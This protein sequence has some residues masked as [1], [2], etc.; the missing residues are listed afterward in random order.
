MFRRAVAVGRYQAAP[1]RTQARY[2]EGV[3]P[4]AAENARPNRA[5]EGNPMSAA[6]HSIR[7][8]VVRSKLATCWRRHSIR[9]RRGVRPC[10]ARKRR[11]TWASLAPN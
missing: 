1:S 9:Y 4:N 8:D 3:M 7:S 6:M 2:S 10:A 11:R 5:L